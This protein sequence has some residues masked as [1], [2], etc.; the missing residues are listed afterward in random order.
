MNA[1]N[2]GKLAR[3]VQERKKET[4]PETLKKASEANRKAREVDENKKLRDWD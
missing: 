1:S 4:L 2:K 3:Q